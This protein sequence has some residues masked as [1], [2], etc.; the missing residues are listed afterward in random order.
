MYEAI[1]VV[2]FLSI[3]FYWDFRAWKKKKAQEL[4]RVKKP[5]I[6]EEHWSLLDGSCTCHTG[7]PPCSFCVDTFVCDMCNERDY[8]DG[9]EET[10]LGFLCDGCTEAECK[11]EMRKTLIILT[12]IWVA[13]IALFLIIYFFKLQNYER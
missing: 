6:I 9:I 1:A 8:A 3:V 12:L 2:I 5:S 7:H 10:K 4:N 11:R 13:V